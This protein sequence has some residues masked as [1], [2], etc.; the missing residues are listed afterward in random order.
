MAKCHDAC[1]GIP[2]NGE[3]EVRIRLL[4]I[5]YEEHPGFH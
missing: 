3:T 5:A 4:Q 2:Q 1:S